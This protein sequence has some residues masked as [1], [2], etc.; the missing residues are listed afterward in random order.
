MKVAPPG[1]NLATVVSPFAFQSSLRGKATA[2]HFTCHHLQQDWC[3]EIFQWCLIPQVNLVEFPI[4]LPQ[5]LCFLHRRHS[6]IIHYK[7]KVLIPG[8]SPTLI[9]VPSETVRRLYSGRC[10]FLSLPSSHALQ[11]PQ[12]HSWSGSVE[13]KVL[14]QV[15]GVGEGNFSVQVGKKKGNL[16]PTLNIADSLFPKDI[17]E[18]PLRERGPSHWTFP[19]TPHWNPSPE[20]ASP[21]TPSSLI[22]AFSHGC[23]LLSTR[24]DWV[25]YSLSTSATT[26]TRLA[27]LMLFSFSVNK[28]GTLLGSLE[29]M[30]VTACCLTSP[31]SFSH[32][33]TC[34]RSLIYG[35][36][37]VKRFT[38]TVKQVEWDWSCH[39]HNPMIQVVGQAGKRAVGEA[40]PTNCPP[41]NVSSFASIFARIQKRGRSWSSSTCPP[42]EQSQSLS[43][44]LPVRRHHNMWVWATGGLEQ[45]QL[46]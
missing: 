21:Q 7:A 27:F 34:P 13:G 14:G 24:H 37:Y 11:S 15:R 32:T 2:L 10:P 3:T 33:P 5:L 41:L 20:V 29:R 6:P 25:E 30:P 38:G 40:T 1:D 18:C 43:S 36:V 42:P 9:S 26:G 45:L 31:N 8:V 28:G 16:L 23:S 35:F 17:L 39:L 44:Y 19:Q 46:C 12:R 4:T 22:N